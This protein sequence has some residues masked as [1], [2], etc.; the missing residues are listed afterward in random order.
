MKA[1]IDNGADVNA[2]NGNQSETPL[3]SAVCC[4]ISP[5]VGVRD[6]DS[7]LISR[8]DI[9]RIFI[10]HGANVNARDKDAQ[11]PLHIAGEFGILC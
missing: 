8:F 7:F 1:L 9:A 11:T 6:I 5:F 4:D 3:H 2:K 10:K